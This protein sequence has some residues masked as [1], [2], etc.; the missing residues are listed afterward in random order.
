MTYSDGQY[1]ALLVDTFSVDRARQKEMSKL[2]DEYAARYKEESFE[3]GLASAS[4]ISKGCGTWRWVC[5]AP[6]YPPT[7]PI[8]TGLSNGKPPFPTGWGRH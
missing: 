5:Q 7:I 3:H 2:A 4:T 6:A 1:V 8:W